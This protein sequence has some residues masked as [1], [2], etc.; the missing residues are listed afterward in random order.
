MT[1]EDVRYEKRNPHSGKP[2]VLTVLVNV[3][4]GSWSEYKVVAEFHA[5]D[6]VG[7]AEVSHLK[8]K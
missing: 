2:D 8:E 4:N 1:G 7:W 6:I 3:N 5:D